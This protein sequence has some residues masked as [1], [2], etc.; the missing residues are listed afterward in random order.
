MHLDGTWIL[1]FNQAWMQLFNGAFWVVTLIVPGEVLSSLL[2][3]VSKQKSDESFLRKSMV[4]SPWEAV[5]SFLTL[6][7]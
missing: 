2:L 5:G 7:L 6:G 4:F 1:H 3:A